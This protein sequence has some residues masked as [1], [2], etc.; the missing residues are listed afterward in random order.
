MFV[1]FGIMNS[2]GIFQAYIAEHQ[3]SHY[4]ESTIGWIF[5]TYTFL[6][7]FCGIQVGPIFDAY[8]PKLLV[9]AGNILLVATMFL[10]G[11]CKEYYQF[12]I[13]F[14]ILGGAGT[15]LL[16]TPSIASVGHF[17]SRRRGLATGIA[18][19]GGSIGG[20]AFSLML[21]SLLPRLGFAWS[22]RI[23]GFVFIFLGGIAQLLI[24]PQ[25]P[26]RP[27]ASILPDFK[28]FKDPAFAILTA[29]VCFVEWGLFTPLTYIPS[30][31]SSTGAFDTAFAYQLI[32]I[33]NAGSSIGRWG[34]GYASD[35]IGRF[36]CLTITLL[37]CFTITIGVWLPATLLAPSTDNT[38]LVS[39]KA[40]TVTYSLLFGIASGANISLTPVCVGQLCETRRYGCFYA[41]CYTVV[42]MW[43]LPGI[44]IA[45]ALLEKSKGRYWSVASFTAAAYACAVVGILSARVLKVGWKVGVKF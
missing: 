30:F 17:F 27:G 42:S 2:M 32:A 1:A 34:A 9:L 39:I 15:S 33:L 40:L 22:T 12:I 29:G 28:I 35:R 31:A 20:I 45:G 13:V 36:N 43:T 10:L 24:H 19:G 7:F 44:P 11:L 41:T 4:D 25:L 6:V 14:G 37:L 26:P 23:L 3:L 18:A 8:G 38:A 16:Y 21:Q 5:S